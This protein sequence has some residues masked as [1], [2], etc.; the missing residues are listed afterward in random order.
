M[1]IHKYQIE[2]SILIYNMKVDEF[3]ANVF[4]YQ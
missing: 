1:K 4:K 2:S 3:E